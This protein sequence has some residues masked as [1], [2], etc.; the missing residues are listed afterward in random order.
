LVAEFLILPPDDFGLLVLLF[1][2]SL[3]TG[4]LECTLVEP[5]ELFLRLYLIFSVFEV[6]TPPLFLDKAFESGWESILV[7]EVNLGKAEVIAGDFDNIG[8]WY[9]LN[10]NAF[11]LPSNGLGALTPWFC[12]GGFFL[13]TLSRWFQLLL[14]VVLKLEAGGFWLD[15]A[16]LE[17]HLV[18]AS[19]LGDIPMWSF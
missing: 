9:V 12:G 16:I 15:P 8:G 19:D 7:V 17:L 18:L 14:A 13:M 2:S 3:I 5:K 10:M 11:V 4:D 6:T 1:S